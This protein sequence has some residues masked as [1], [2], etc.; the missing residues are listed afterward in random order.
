[1]SNKSN[2]LST[3]VGFV[4]VGKEVSFDIS[5]EKFNKQKYFNNI[6]IKTKELY[7]FF[8]S[9]DIVDVHMIAIA[10]YVFIILHELGHIYR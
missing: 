4:V 5:I 8:Q 3:S 6:L 10:G 2:F 9:F 1:M 7:R